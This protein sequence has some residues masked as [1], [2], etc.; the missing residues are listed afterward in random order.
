MLFDVVENLRIVKTEEEIGKIAKA[1]EIAEQ[2][3]NHIVN[4]IKPGASE[5]DLALELEFFMRK[6]GASA[7][8]FSIIVASGS[9]S[10]LPHGVASGK[11]IEEGELVLLDFGCVYEGYCSDMTRVLKLGKLTDE[12]KYIWSIVYNAHMK[13]CEVIVNGER[14]CKKIHKAAEELISAEGFG[15]Y[16]GHGLGHGVGLEIHEKP[17]LSALSKDSLVDGAV[18][19]IEPGIYLPGKFGI[20]LENIYTLKNE[21]LECLN[22][23]SLDLMEL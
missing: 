22:R 18:F 3:F 17:T 7:A 5:K 19:T 11:N 9:R 16:F 1:V 15:E 8:S 10:A 6:S 12:E 13:A 21:K 14:D 20:R 23:S 4:F 2:A